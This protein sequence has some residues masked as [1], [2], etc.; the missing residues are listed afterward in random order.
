MGGC[1]ERRDRLEPPAAAPWRPLYAA[2]HR[3]PLPTS[4]RLTAARTREPR[5]HRP[6]QRACKGLPYDARRGSG[7]LAPKP[8]FVVAVTRCALS[9]ARRCERRVSTAAPSPSASTPRSK[10]ALAF[11]RRSAF[12]EVHLDF[13]R[14]RPARPRDL[15]GV[16]SSAKARRGRRRAPVTFGCELRVVADQRRGLLRRQALGGPA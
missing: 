10:Y 12:A 9:A 5:L 2:L 8:S 1:S 3:R 7:S 14:V 13:L 4:S 11:G 6:W 15:R 16:A